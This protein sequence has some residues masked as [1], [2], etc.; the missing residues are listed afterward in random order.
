MPPQV[1]LAGLKAKVGWFK[2]GVYSVNGPKVTF[3]D[4]P[5]RDL[6]QQGSRMAA[7]RRSRSWAD[8]LQ[9][10]LNAPLH[11]I[12]SAGFAQVFGSL[13]TKIAF[14]RFERPPYAFGML[15]AADQAAQLGIT[16]IAAIEFGVASGIGLLSMC[17]IAAAVSRH[18]GVKIDVVGF[19]T[20]AGMPAAQDYRDHPEYYAQADFAMP[21]P[22]RLRAALPPFAQLILG[23]IA[24]TAP[25]FLR[26]YEHVIGF[27]AVDVDYH[28]SAAK[29]LAMLN[30][31]ADKY[32]PLVPMFF[33]DV[34]LDFHNPWCGELLAIEEFNRLGALR[35]IAPF[36]ALATKRALKNASWI[37][38]MYAL[39]VLD[40]RARTVAGNAQAPTRTM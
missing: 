8:R 10:A 17:R 39:H 32:L 14:D 24:E 6:G 13:R 26:R 4:T 38:Q 16:R 19:D 37:A 3:P 2:C 20:G 35:K 29:C 9:G 25:E 27:V 23:D 7:V 1:G 33:D 40:H 12:V 15:K 11:V 21:D 18:T 5:A 34:I 30:G 22:E 28:S 31:A 36:T